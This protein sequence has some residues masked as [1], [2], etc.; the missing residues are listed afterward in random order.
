MEERRMYKRQ[1][2]FI[3]MLLVI[4]S[5]V[6]CA[7]SG[8]STKFTPKQNAT[9]WMEVYNSTYDSTMATM[10]N[11][12]STQDQKNI[13]LQKK[14]ILAEVWPL[15]KI[16]VATV[17]A[18]KVPTAEMESAITILIDRLTALAIGGK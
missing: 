13:A 18:G 4:I 8:T 14:A 12:A 1:L 9:V 16:Y 17:E 3:I 11:P 5:L 6:G 2:Q 7:T 15:L 10:K